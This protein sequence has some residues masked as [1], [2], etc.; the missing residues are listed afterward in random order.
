MIIKNNMILKKVI[1]TSGILL[2]IFI[3]GSMLGIT[4][5]TS[6]FI[7]D[8]QARLGRPATAN[9]VAGVSR[10]TTRRRVYHTNRY[11]RVLPTRCTVVIVDD[12]S[13]HYC[14][15]VYYLPHVRRYRVVTV[16]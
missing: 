13:L 8:A 12:T 7:N 9:S 16:K 4:S 6:F 10:R 1:L 3:T 15:G 14:S 2:I 5:I 11:V